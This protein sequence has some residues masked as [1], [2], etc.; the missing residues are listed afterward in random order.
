MTT[1]NLGAASAPR[2]SL[3]T[4]YLLLFL[5]GALGAH[6]FYL[7]R[8]GRG[9]LYACTLGGLGVFVLIDMFSLPGQVAMVNR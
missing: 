1:V 5:L 3:S 8:V 4:A 9:V 7:G 6:Q 2:K